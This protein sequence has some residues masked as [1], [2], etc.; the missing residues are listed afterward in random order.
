MA[1][2]PKLTDKDRI[3]LAQKEKQM[4]EFRYRSELKRDVTI[5]LSSEH[6]HTTGLKCDVVQVI[7]I[8]IFST[9]LRM[10]SSVKMPYTRF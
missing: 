7:T 2:K 6:F 10:F 9:V 3:T 8:F 4:H 5:A 1:N